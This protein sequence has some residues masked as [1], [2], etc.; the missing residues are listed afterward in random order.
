MRVESCSSANGQRNASADSKA[1]PEFLPALPVRDSPRTMFAQ[2]HEQRGLSPRRASWR[3][4]RARYHL[5][6][7]HSFS[8][9]PRF[10]IEHAPNFRKSLSRTDCSCRGACAKRL[11]HWFGASRRRAP[12]QQNADCRRHGQHH[13]YS[14]ANCQFLSQNS[15]S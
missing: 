1:V 4:R 5:L 15:R 7:A 8:R 2:H 10:E 11:P 14:L 12:L 9:R 3:S 6:S 13:N